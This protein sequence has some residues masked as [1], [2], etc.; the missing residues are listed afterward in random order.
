MKKTDY[1][2]R[3][4]GAAAACALAAL[5]AFAAQQPPA[6]QAPPAAPPARPPRQ[7]QPAPPVAT[8]PYTLTPTTNGMELKTP[9]G[10]VVLEYLTSKPE[11][12]PLTSP[13]AACFHPVNTPKGERVTNIAP[14]DHPHHRGI[15]FGWHDAEFHT[16]EVVKADF[17]A[18][19]VA[20]P[21][22]GRL[23]QNTEL[24]LVSADNKQ[25]KIA[26]HNDWL[27]EG[28]KFGDETDSATVSERDGVYVLD[29]AYTVDPKYEFVANKTAFGGFDVQCR[30]DGDSYFSNFYGKVT[31]TDPQF[32]NPELN[33]PSMPWYDFTIKLKDNGKVIGAAVVNH[34][35]NPPTTW[36]SPSYLYMLNPTIVGAGPVTIKPG[37]PLTL[38]YRVI[39]HDGP[40]PTWVIQKLSEEYRGGR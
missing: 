19:G 10:R 7:A 23:V 27:V 22:E 4:T 11:G 6:Q 18:W 16:P 35:D 8:G 20:A 29:L 9:D 25:A 2:L 38:R 12:V 28:K 13:S 1:L 31:Y 15:F 30:K 34:P 5:C 40:T 37:S 24:K 21:R 39:V 14:S 26:I 33:L 3:F 17:W 32:R 36:H